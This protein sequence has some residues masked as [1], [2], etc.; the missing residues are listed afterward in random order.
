MNVNEDDLLVGLV[1]DANR[2][3]MAEPWPITLFVHGLLVSGL[4]VGMDEFYQISFGEGPK[5]ADEAEIPARPRFIHLKDAKIFRGGSAGLITRPGGEGFPWRGR[6]S[7]VDG[8]L[9]G[10][11]E[12]SKEADVIHFPGPR[13]LP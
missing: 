5:E 10:R 6:L 13:A 2:G 4:I 12:M 11:M 1:Y 7:S 9:L 8:Y 3:K